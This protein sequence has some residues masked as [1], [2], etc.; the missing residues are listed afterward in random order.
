MEKSKKAATAQQIAELY[1]VNTGTLANLRSLGRGARYFKQGRK[2][3]YFLSDFENWL[4][5]N[6]VQTADSHE[7]VETR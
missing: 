2:V 6:P 1:G 5:S 7:L 3:I 4:K